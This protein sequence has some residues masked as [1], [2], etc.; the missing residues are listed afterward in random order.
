[1][2]KTVEEYDAIVKAQA[3]HYIASHEMYQETNAQLTKWGVQNHPM[4]TGPER[5]VLAHTDVNLDLRTALELEHIF[6]EKTERA[7]RDGTITYWDI[8]LEEIFEA[9]AASSPLELEEELVQA[10][11]VIASMI[12]ASRRARGA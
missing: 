2:P 6:R 9:A 1:M 4:G 7:A 8:L 11:A 3:A 5:R 10:G 12:A